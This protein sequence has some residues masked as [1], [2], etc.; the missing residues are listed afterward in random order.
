MSKYNVPYQS[1][2]PKLWIVFEEGAVCGGLSKTAANLQGVWGY[3]AR[4]VGQPGHAAYVYLYNAGGGKYAWQ[5]SNSVSTTGWTNTTG[6]GYNGWGSRYSFNNNTISTGSYLL[7]S[8]DAQNEY[9][10]YYIKTVTNNS[11]YHY[12]QKVH[13]FYLSHHNK[14]LY[15]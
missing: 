3:P 6:G 7:L 11:V 9:E 15:I 1:G 12:S 13:T 8:Q 5:L 10:K 4:V 14:I 2:K